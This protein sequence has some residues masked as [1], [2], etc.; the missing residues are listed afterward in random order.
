MR[1]YGDTY[2]SKLANGYRRQNH[3]EIPRLSYPR[4]RVSRLFCRRGFPLKDC[5]NDTVMANLDSSDKRLQ[6]FKCLAERH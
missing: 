4:K 2:V 5:G 1:N 3:S 6:R